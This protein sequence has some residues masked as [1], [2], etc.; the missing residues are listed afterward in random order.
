MI[1]LIC[2]VLLL[3]VLVLSF[4]LRKK[5]KQEREL[6]MR[7]NLLIENALIGKDIREVY[8]E[9]FLSRI[10]GRFLEFL[11]H[12]YLVKSKLKG[13][14]EK[15]KELIS[16]ISHQTKN[17]IAN[18]RLYTELLMEEP[19]PDSAKESTKQLSAQVEKITF[20]IDSLIKMSRLES[21]IIKL[22]PKKQSIKKLL[23]KIE[24]Q[25]VHQARSKN[26]SFLIESVDAD[27]NYDLKWTAE[28]IG[29]IVDNAIKYTDEGAVRISVHPLEMFLKLEISDTGF[30]IPSEEREKVFQRFYR[31]DRVIEREGLGIGLYLSRNIMSLQGGYIQLSCNPDMGSNF[32]VF[33]PRN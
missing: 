17:P 21:R 3:A 10:E 19:L 5:S 28:A 30:G 1:E 18:L 27:A 31:S 16:D 4:M 14:Q 7:L 23:E 25:F 20:L 6:L 26:L 29:N 32:S 9:S 2:G 12:S 33:L 11:N 24:N 22:N 13:E 8:D 15:I